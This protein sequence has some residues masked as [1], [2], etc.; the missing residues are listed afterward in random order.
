MDTARS[1]NFS[2]V[3]FTSTIQLAYTLP[4]L[5]ITPV[6]SILST[7]FCAVPL[8]MRVEPVI[9]SGPVSGTMATCARLVISAF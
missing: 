3:A 2:L 8:F 1:H 4:S 7:I 9:T 5:I 6:E